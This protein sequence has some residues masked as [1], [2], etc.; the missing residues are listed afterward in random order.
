M[1]I[2]FRVCVDYCY[3]QRNIDSVPSSIIPCIIDSVP[4][5]GEVIISYS[6]CDVEDSSETMIV[7][8]L[9]MLWFFF[10]KWLQIFFLSQKMLI[11][12]DLLL[13]LVLLWKFLS[14]EQLY[15]S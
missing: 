10:L 3:N 5:A 7:D 15:I 6:T 11:S 8:M 4:S 2:R 12:R 9:C 13:L 1:T 14:T